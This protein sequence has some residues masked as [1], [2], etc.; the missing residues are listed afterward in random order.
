LIN[1]Q[2]ETVDANAALS[3]KVVGLYFSG[4]WCSPCKE[5]TKTL[6]AT[7]QTL[8]GSDK[9]FE[10]VLVPVNDASHAAY[11]YLSTQPWL[12]VPPDA[13]LRLTRII[14]S[15]EIQ[16]V[17]TLLIYDEKGELITPHGTARLSQPGE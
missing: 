14:S 5:F 8:L 12:S 10:V 2:N 16:A 15:A 4:S 9:P 7:Y 17:P 1:A 6:K 11:E 13:A 3:G